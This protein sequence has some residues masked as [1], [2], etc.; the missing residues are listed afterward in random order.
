MS[1]GSGQKVEAQTLA[2]AESAWSSSD[3]LGEVPVSV[4]HR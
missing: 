4:R 3:F 2:M 1:S